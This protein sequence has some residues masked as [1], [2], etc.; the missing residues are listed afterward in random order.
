MRMRAARWWV[1][2]MSGICLAGKPAA[3]EVLSATAERTGVF[4]GAAVGFGVTSPGLRC[5]V[6]IRSSDA[7]RGCGDLALT[8]DGG[9]LLS[10]KLG[11]ALQ[12]AT[13][14]PFGLRSGAVHEINAVTL[15]YWP[16]S[17]LWIRAGAGWGSRSDVTEWRQGRHLA[18]ISAAGYEIW[19]TRRPGKRGEG[20]MDLQLRVFTT[21]G[22]PGV[23]TTSASLSVGMAMFQTRD[24]AAPNGS[25]SAARAAQQLPERMAQPEPR[26]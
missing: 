14:A 7:L 21:G 13:A 19:R 2:L 26:P 24:V 3:A 15:Q 22:G 12:F 11:G 8:I 18:V 23:R 17:R 1:I 10:R 25:S 9:W 5:F 6:D 20:T 4:V 16:S